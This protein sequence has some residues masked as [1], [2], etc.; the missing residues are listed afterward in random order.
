MHLAQSRMIVSD[1][2]PEQRTGGAAFAMVK[3]ALISSRYLCP[4]LE[5]CSHS[6]PVRA[7]RHHVQVQLRSAI[8]DDTSAVS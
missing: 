8:S 1:A 5:P 6:P 4:S 3:P 2:S 7:G